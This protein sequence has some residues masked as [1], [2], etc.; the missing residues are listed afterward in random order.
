MGKE[1]C[2]HCP[3]DGIFRGEIFRGGIRRDDIYTLSSV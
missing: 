2:I 3:F 1:F